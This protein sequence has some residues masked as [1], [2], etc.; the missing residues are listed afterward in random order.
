M[1]IYCK[2]NVYVNYV[3]DFVKRHS[4]WKT[5]PSTRSRC[6]RPADALWPV[7]INC[8]SVLKTLL[9]C[10]SIIVFFC[11]FVFFNEPILNIFNRTISNSGHN[12]KKNT[13]RS[14]LWFSVLG[15]F[16]DCYEKSIS[17]LRYEPI[18]IMSFYYMTH[19]LTHFGVNH[20]LDTLKNNNNNL[21]SN[22]FLS[23]MSRPVCDIYV[24]MKTF[25]PNTAFKRD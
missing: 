24:Y 5:F 21:R 6:W 4:L 3:Y 22:S 2:G 25:G 20:A 17:Y 10:A 16:Y 13:G 18:Q 9:L 14:L 23:M 1:A 19:W 7:T 11:L 8:C 15:V 12:K